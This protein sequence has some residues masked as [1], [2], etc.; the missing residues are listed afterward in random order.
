MELEGMLT[1]LRQPHIGNV[2][3]VGVSHEFFTVFQKQGHYFFS[4]SREKELQKQN[5]YNK[6][7]L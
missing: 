2:S 4:L 6:N 1:Y 3:K 7:H 5:Q